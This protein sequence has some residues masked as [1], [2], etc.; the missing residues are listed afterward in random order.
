MEEKKKTNEKEV[1]M[2]ECPFCNKPIEAPAKADVIFECPHCHK[3]LITYEKIA[4]QGKSMQN[5]NTQK[6]ILK[7]GGIIAFISLLL[8][9]S[10]TDNVDMNATYVVTRDYDAAINVDTEKA[11]VKA[12]VDGDNMKTL[13]IIGK[14]QTIHFYSGDLVKITRSTVRGLPD[15]YRV[16]RISDGASALIP[17]KYLT[18]M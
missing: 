18:K 10:I 5:S 12:A 15:H 13:E 16:T 7:W 6:Q 4:K 17:K 3:E 9:I 1:A 11:L 2:V 14:Q 8:C